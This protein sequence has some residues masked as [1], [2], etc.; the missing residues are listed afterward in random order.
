MFWFRKKDKE[1][2]EVKVIAEEQLEKNRE[3]FES[4]KE[5]DEGKKEISTTN[6]KAH[7]RDIQTTP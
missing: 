5:Y 4:L 7:L 6:V 2:S 1:E 3:V